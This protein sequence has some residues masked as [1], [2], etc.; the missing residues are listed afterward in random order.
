[1]SEEKKNI[2]LALV[3]DAATTEDE[4]ANGTGIHVYNIT[5]VECMDPRFLKRIFMIQTEEEVPELMHGAGP[6]M[7]GEI[8][9]AIFGLS[10]AI[11]S[12]TDD[13]LVAQLKKQ[14]L[15]PSLNQ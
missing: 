4:R 3:V 6:K 10:C 12:L 8:L 11:H 7:N 9:K 14:G 13:E 1:M 15:V 5:S 2:K